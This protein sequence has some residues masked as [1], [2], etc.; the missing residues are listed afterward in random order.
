MLSS[1]SSILLKREKEK[2]ILRTLRQ[3]LGEYVTKNQRLED[4]LF[5]L[6]N[7]FNVVNNTLSETKKLNQEAAEEKEE[8]LTELKLVL[9][10]QAITNSQKSNPNPQFL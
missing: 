2:E 9:E 3:R 6:Q 1:H 8:E 7:K 10:N 4:E 5:A